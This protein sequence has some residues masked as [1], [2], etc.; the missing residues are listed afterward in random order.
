MKFLMY[1]FKNKEQSE[2]VKRRFKFVFLKKIIKKIY[3]M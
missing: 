3:I 1:D 2:R